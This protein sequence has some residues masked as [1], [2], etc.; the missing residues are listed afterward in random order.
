MQGPV[1]DLVLLMLLTLFFGLQQRR[2][3]QIY[4]RFWFAGWIFVF[5]SYVVWAVQG[6]PA[7]LV[8]LQNAVCFDFLLMGVLTFLMSMV[9]KDQSLRKIVLCGVAIG[10]VAMIMVD[11]QE[12]LVIPRLL[13]AAEV[14]LAGGLGFSIGYA[15][16]PRRWPRR[17]GMILAIC[18]VSCAALTSYVLLTPA[19][20]LDSAVVVEVLLC[21]AVLYAG[22]AAR[23]GVSGWAGT[24]GFAAWAA[25]YLVNMRP[26]NPAWMQKVLYEFWNFPKYFVGF[27]MILKVFEDTA[28]DKARMV[29][30]FRDLYEDFRLLYDTHPHPMWICDAVT[31]QLLTANEAALK[32]YGYSLEELQGMRMAE[33][34]VPGD[35]EAEEVENILGESTEGARVRHRYKS[36]R[37]AWVNVVEREIM[38]LGKAARLVIARNIT[39]RMKLD[40]ELSYRAQHD[41]LTGLPNRQLL[42][43]RLDQC[44]QSSR[45]EDRRAAVLTVDVDHFKMINDTYGHLVGDECLKEVAARLKSKIR[46]VDT[47]ARTGGEEF[48]AI[49][50]GLSKASDAEKVAASLMRVFEAPVELAFGAMGVTVSIGVAV[51]PD[52]ATDATTLRR[53]SDEAMYRAKRAGR[54]RAAYASDKTTVL[55]FKKPEAS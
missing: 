36:G 54:N 39:E 37:V 13:L 2:R 4:F 32:E 10:G 21:A 50:S 5:L 51:Y 43:E 3:P 18:V 9:A 12:F 31:G 48:T 26:D 15:L 11:T 40:R 46:K 22:S 55:D 41:V 17:R 23:R 30:T 29:E 8:R 35:A 33:L 19:T 45:V 1:V 52:D 49:V 25:F 38:Y 53:L 34:E 42:E 24:F 14:L 20:N 47:I 27:S 28:D 44:L 6:V 7:T 16:L